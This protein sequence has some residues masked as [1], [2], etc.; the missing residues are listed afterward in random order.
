MHR[1]QLEEPVFGCGKSLKRG[2][3]ICYGLYDIICIY[4]PHNLCC[5][6]LSILTSLSYLEKSLLYKQLSCGCEISNLI[7]LAE[8]G[9]LYKIGVEIGDSISSSDYPVIYINWLNPL[10]YDLAVFYHNGD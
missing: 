4:Y 5:C 3:Q 6:I 7:T 10:G 9:N 1:V 8:L 2:C